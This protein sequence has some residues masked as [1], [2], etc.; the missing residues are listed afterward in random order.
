MFVAALS[1]V[2]Q[3]DEASGKFQHHGAKL[4]SSPPNDYERPQGTATNVSES[5]TAWAHGNNVK[6]PGNKAQW[7]DTESAKPPKNKPQ[8]QGG[9]KL[10]SNENKPR[11]SDSGVSKV[12]SKSQWQDDIQHQNETWRSSNPIDPVKKPPWKDTDA[13]KAKDNNELV[14][15]TSKSKKQPKDVTKSISESFS[16]EPVLM[17][18]PKVTLLSR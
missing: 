7:F 8:W 9:A 14:A 1:D 18:L 13:N 16:S 6:P 5:E 10:E 4:Y 12:V 2:V 17:K 15:T 3:H 11:W